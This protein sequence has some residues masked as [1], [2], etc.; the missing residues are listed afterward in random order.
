[1]GLGWLLCSYFVLHCMTAGI[2]SITA[3]DS[4][5]ADLV[6]ILYILGALAGMRAIEK[7]KAYNPR[8]AWLYAPLAAYACL[9]VFSL[10][11][12]V[13]YHF[14][15]A[16]L[17]V[18]FGET[19]ETVASLVQF[20]AELAFSLIALFSSAEL[21][22]S[23][24]L[25]RQQSKATRNMIFVAIWAIAQ[26][27][28][29]LATAFLPL[30]EKAQTEVIPT[31][32]AI[33]LVYQLI[34]YLLNTLIFYSCFSAI[35]PEGEEF[36]KPSK[37]SRFAFIN[38]INQKLDEKNERARLEYEQMIADQNKKYSAKN[39]NRHHKKKK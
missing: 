4:I 35:C 7:L 31:L 29:L 2:P 18:L 1:M 39:N 11:R 25:Q 32:S 37:P 30:G 26:L 3:S 16:D 9:A 13:N 33:L 21:A 28:L 5:F 34:V 36:G 24:G 15:L 8:Y 17:S 27:A 23:V 38:N 6:C 20:A 22:A 19:V 12:F 14:L 10:V